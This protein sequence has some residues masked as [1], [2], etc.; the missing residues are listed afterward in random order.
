MEGDSQDSDRTTVAEALVTLYDTLVSYGL[1]AASVK[2]EEYRASRPC[3]TK[4]CI[5][6]RGHWG[7]CSD[8]DKL[9]K[10]TR[11][12]SKIPVRR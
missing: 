5:G 2:L 10:T 8:G 7:P 1:R 9:L 11:F 3:R 4:G 6:I 12:K